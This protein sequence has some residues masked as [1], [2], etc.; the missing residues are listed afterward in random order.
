[1][2]TYIIKIVVVKYVSFIK[3]IIF[4]KKFILNFL[5]YLN[6]FIFIYLCDFN[7]VYNIINFDFFKLNFNG[8]NFSNNNDNDLSDNENYS[9]HEIN[10]FKDKIKKF[11]NF[12]ELN[13]DEKLCYLKSK[14]Y[15][16]GLDHN[17][18][19]LDWFVKSIDSN[20]NREKVQV[21]NYI[22]TNLNILLKL[23]RDT[24]LKSHSFI[25]INPF[26]KTFNG[27]LVYPYVIP[28]SKYSSWE[29]IEMDLKCK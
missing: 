15:D 6:L 17:H 22:E 19:I 16:K 3:F 5:F 2:I 26:L 8:N 21:D 7:N 4:L 11:N 12:N 14:Y 10:P 9:D 23:S 13:N 18:H 29:L 25:R 1:M 20:T 24:A 28:Q 27:P